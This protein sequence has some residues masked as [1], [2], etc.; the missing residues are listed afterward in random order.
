MSVQ[1]FNIFQ[2][3]ADLKTLFNKAIILLTFLSNEK[4]YKSK[5]KIKYS[6]SRRRPKIVTL[7]FLKNFVDFKDRDKVLI[8]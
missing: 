1:M 5:L 3:Y 4:N 7:P 8:S 6:F 2:K